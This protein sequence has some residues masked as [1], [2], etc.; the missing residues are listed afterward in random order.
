MLQFLKSIHL[1]IDLLTLISRL[2][3]NN[4]YAKPRLTTHKTNHRFALE[5]FGWNKAKTDE[6]LL[7]VIKKVHSVNQVRYCEWKYMYYDVQVYQLKMYSTTA[8]LS[9]LI[10]RSFVV[11]DILYFAEEDNRIFTRSVG[12]T[13]HCKLVPKQKAA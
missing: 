10:L 11:K 4:Q 1:A 3:T 6:V 12:S 2:G 9:N 5:K 8:L 7:P 13:R